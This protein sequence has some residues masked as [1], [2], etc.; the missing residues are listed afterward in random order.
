MLEKDR[1]RL[2]KMAISCLRKEGEKRPIFS[3]N[4]PSR[5]EIEKIKKSLETGYVDENLLK[6][7][8]PMAY[9]GVNKHGFFEYFF[10]VHNK[11]IGM[12]ERYTKHRLVEWCTAYPAKIVDKKNSKWVAER[13]DGKRIITDSEAYPGITIEKNLKIGDLVI[14]HRDKIH[15]VLDK[16]EF[17]TA[18]EFFNKFKK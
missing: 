14:L 10:L 18:L 7:F 17:E 9:Q 12:L 11:T 15:M 1:L 3:P 16:D 13:P 4:V 8:F 5:E 6:K 2:L